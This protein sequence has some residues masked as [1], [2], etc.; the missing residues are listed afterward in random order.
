[1][2]LALSVSG[3]LRREEVAAQDNWAVSCFRCVKCELRGGRWQVV[4]VKESHMG[5][6][7]KDPVRY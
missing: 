7:G 1:V 4:P 2:G 5:L 3:D 6:M